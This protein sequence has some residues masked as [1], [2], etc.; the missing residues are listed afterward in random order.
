[1]KI[2]VDA[3]CLGVTD[4]R[5]KVGV[6][7]FAKNLLLHLSKID[8]HNQYFLYSFSPIEKSFLKK[9][10][11]NMK[12]IV[13]KPTKGWLTIWLPI[14]MVRDRI[15]L[16]LTLSQAVPPHMSPLTRT[17]GYIHDIAFEKNPEFYGSDYDPLHENV[18]NVAKKSD[19]IVVSAESV[20]QDLI[21][22]LGVDEIKI[23]V[24]PMGVRQ[25][26]VNKHGRKN[27]NRNY[28]LYVGALKKGKNV[29]S[30]LRAF[31][32]FLKKSHMDYELI[33]VGGDKWLD[34][35][36][37]KTL[38]TISDE[39]LEKIIFIGYVKDEELAE[40]YK[41]ATAFVSPSFHEG[42][43]LPFVEAMASGTPVIGSN[44]GSIPEVVGDAGI[45]VDPLD[46]SAIAQA[47]QSLAKDKKLRESFAK[48]GLARS[49]GYSWERTAKEVYSL[50]ERFT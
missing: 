36:I 22:L 33:V 5:L 42:F 25:L 28:F 39:T 11:P 3:G 12:N 27:L 46:S 17:L 49:K 21:S 2:G 31:D 10:G 13:V 47:M 35:D 48:N 23:K 38:D 8:N 7:N 4:E 6:Y 32:Q 37:Q 43:G 34:S 19:I 29:P 26:P 16:F 24:I 15:D 1:M 14:R 20:K 50:I 44:R 45:L 9:L 18:V 30:I 40:L 41:N